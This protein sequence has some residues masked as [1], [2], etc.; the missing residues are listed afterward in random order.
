[1]EKGKIRDIHMRFHGYFGLRTKAYQNLGENEMAMDNS[2]LSIAGT[3]DDKDK[4]RISETMGD[5]KG[6]GEI[7]LKG[8]RESKKGFKMVL[9]PL[10]WQ[11][12]SA[13]GKNSTF[14]GLKIVS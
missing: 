11:K 6:G 9:F 14:L 10:D 5:Q 13:T 4:R 12:I 3:Y 1:V 8:N 2:Q 7:G